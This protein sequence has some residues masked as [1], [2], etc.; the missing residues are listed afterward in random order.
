MSR[1][2]TSRSGLEISPFDSEPQSVAEIRSGVTP[3]CSHVL[4]PGA[5]RRTE[6]SD[7]TIRSSRSRS[8]PSTAEAT[9][10]TG[11][12]GSGRRLSY[13]CRGRA[14]PLEVGRTGHHPAVGQPQALALEVA[15]GFQLPQGASDGDLALV[16][17]C[18]QLTDADGHPIGERLDVDRDADRDQRQP[19]VL[20]EV[21]ADD[22]EAFGM[23]MADVLDARARGNARARLR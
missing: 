13:G 7:S 9:G 5:S 19:A 20:G 10:S 15:L 23:T 21:V 8:L 3:R 12:V 22:G 18:R 4:T 17:A 14:R 2:S 1:H 16:E 11:A 6:R